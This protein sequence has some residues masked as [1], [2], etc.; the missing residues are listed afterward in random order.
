MFRRTNKN[1]FGGAFTYFQ[2]LLFGMI[3][4]TWSDSTASNNRINSK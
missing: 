4:F 3:L 1:Y 2:L